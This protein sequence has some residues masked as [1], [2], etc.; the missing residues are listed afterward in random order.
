MTASAHAPGVVYAYGNASNPV[1]TIAS[2]PAYVTGVSWTFDWSQ[3]EPASGVYDWTPIDA[4]ISAS[5]GRYAMIRVIPGAHSPSWVQPTVTFWDVPGGKLPPHYVTMP[6]P[7]D[8]GFLTAWTAF[9]AAYGARYDHAPV[10]VVQ[11]PGAGILGEMGLGGWDQASNPP[12]SYGATD[13]GFINAW[14]QIIAAYRSAFPDKPT[15][16]DLGDPL[17]DGAVEPVIIAYAKASGGIWLQ[18]NNLAPKVGSG[19]FNDILNGSAWTTTGWQMWAG[20]DTSAQIS[21][22]LKVASASHANY[23]EVYVSDCVNPK[24]KAAIT[25]FT[26]P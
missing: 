1:Q 16:L 4:A 10:T 25:A 22:S 26:K 17:N 8:Q 20:N 23:V 24:N 3:I 5:A 13:Q 9:I 11:M 21:A 12:Q 2:L 19:P 6:I 18:H 14:E 7:W 15:A